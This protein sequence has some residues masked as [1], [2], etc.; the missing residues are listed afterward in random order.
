MYTCTVNKLI[1]VEKE[2]EGKCQIVN[3]LERNY[4]RSEDKDISWVQN[5]WHSYLHM[6]F[7]NEL[8][9]LCCLLDS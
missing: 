2:V 5:L 7:S 6:L 4:K 8:I 9:I 3:A 1:L